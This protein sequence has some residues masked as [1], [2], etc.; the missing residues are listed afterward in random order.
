MFPTLY[1]ALVAFPLILG[2]V[3]AVTNFT[4]A[5]MQTYLDGNVATL[6]QR[7]APIWFFSEM[8]SNLPCIPDWAFGGSPD[9]SDVYDASHITP[10]AAQCDYPNVGCNCRNPGVPKS[11]AL[12]EFPIYYVSEQC[13]TTEV[14]IAYNVFYQKDGAEF[15][16]IQT[17]HNYD[18]ERVI[19]VH[20]KN[21]DTTWQPSE[22]I[23]SY[24]SGDKKIEW[25]DI[26]NTLSDEDY[27]A[28]KSTDPNGLQDLDHPKVYVGWSKHSH[29][30]TRNTGVLISIICVLTLL[31]R[32][33][34]ER[35]CESIS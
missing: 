10:P 13:N 19:V 14:R 16:G 35:S 32:H 23:L 18:W 6:A 3:N 11:S 24:H 1:R 7:Y 5:Q 26:Q 25:P 4:D 34:L 9:T 31:S 22:V 21:S 28:G 2:T 15:I 30:D 29:F 20:S 8:D 17:G 27:N 33:R 12:P